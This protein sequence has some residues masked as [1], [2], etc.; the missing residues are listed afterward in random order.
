MILRIILTFFVLIIQLLI[1]ELF[2]IESKNKFPFD[3]D[4][5]KMKGGLHKYPLKHSTDSLSNR[6]ILE[7]QDKD[8]LTIWFAR[9]FYKDI[10][11][12]DICRMAKFWIFWDG[13][14]NYLGYR[15]NENDSL[16]KSDHIEFLSD[17]YIK[18]HEILSDSTSMLKDLFYEDL[19]IK[20]EN[21]NK[22]EK[23]LFDVDGCTSAT[24][25]A[26]S[27]YVV[28]DAV[29][30]CYTLWHTVYGETRT[31]IKD[32]LSK[33]VNLRYVSALMSGNNT[34]KLFAIEIAKQDS[35]YFIKFELQYLK[36]IA[37]QDRNLSEKALSLISQE[38][39]NIQQNQLKFIE[40]IDD[41]LGKIRFEVI[42]KLQ[43]LENISSDAVMLLLNKCLA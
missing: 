8:G 25:P 40:L 35:S 41:S 5:F 30:T 27:K 3:N 7:L 9:F 24:P 14:G 2:T 28:K 26:L 22:N 10:C 33:R 34:Q 12:T 36:M 21:R 39:L 1:G 42:N 32:I 20:L 6:E 15:L 23:T 29:F 16:T 11:I 38:Y 31:Q 17:D 43:L 19:A 18:L 4:Y 37:S 13:S